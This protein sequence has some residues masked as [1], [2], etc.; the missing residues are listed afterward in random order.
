M[1]VILPN[2]S[3]SR[4]GQ[5]AYISQAKYLC[6]LYSNS[7]V[8]RSKTPF[9][10]LIY[11]EQL[12]DLNHFWA[13]LLQCHSW[14]HTPSVFLQVPYC[15]LPIVLDCPY[16][17]PTIELFC[18]PSMFTSVEAIH[19]A[20]SMSTA[21]PVHMILLLSSGKIAQEGKDAAAVYKVLILHLPMR[22]ISHV[23]DPGIE[24][25]LVFY[26]WLHIQIIH[27]VHYSAQL[28]PAQITTYCPSNIE[29]LHEQGVKTNYKAKN[30]LSSPNYLQILTLDILFITFLPP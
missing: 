9:K 5:L 6:S 23:W 21:T 30:L 26:K 17:K 3:E 14:C 28:P 8:H 1:V 2:E 15:C 18:Y 10:Q 13:Q 29:F 25:I 27:L 24:S 12:V 11:I 7:L 22:Q 19:S 20:I 4:D 16:S